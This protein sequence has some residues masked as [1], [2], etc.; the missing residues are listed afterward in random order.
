MSLPILSRLFSS[1]KAQQAEQLGATSFDSDRKR[2]LNVGGN[3]KEASIPSVYDGWLNVVLDIDP[4]GRPD[5][6]CD[7]R[8]LVS[9]SPHAYES[10]Y[11][12]HNLEHYFRH[13][14]AKVLAGFMHVLKEDGFVYIRVPDMGQLMQ[15]V[16]RDGLDIDDFLYSS[17]MGP[18]TVR[19]VIYGHAGEIESSGSDFY[20]HKTGFTPKSLIAALVNAGFPFLYMATD[21]LEVTAFAFIKE[22]SADMMASLNIVAA[23]AA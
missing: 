9:L 15:Q 10:I 4:T 20:A 2:V 3:N 17:P 5:V 7:A 11:C 14:V 6:V 13:D 22:P 18:I 16:V 12:S 8:D 1:K 23:P 21:Y 19:D